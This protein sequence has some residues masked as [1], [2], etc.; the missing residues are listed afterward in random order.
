MKIFQVQISSYIACGNALWR[1]SKILVNEIKMNYIQ[2]EKSKFEKD[3]QF[4][5]IHASSQWSA[6]TAI[7]FDISNLGK[8][9]WQGLAKARLQR[10]LEQIIFN[11]VFFKEK[12]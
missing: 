8:K 9:M 4:R 1:L 7:R 12:K 6:A 2:L 5:K 3:I 10:V 11:S